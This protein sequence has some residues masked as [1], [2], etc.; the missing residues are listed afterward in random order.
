[1]TFERPFCWTF[2]E[3]NTQSITRFWCWVK[4][5]LWFQT[6]SALLQLFG[7]PQKKCIQGGQSK[8]LPLTRVGFGRVLAAFSTDFLPASAWPSTALWFLP[9]AGVTGPGTCQGQ[10][11]A[12]CFRWALKD[13]KG[14]YE[15]CHWPWIASGSPALLFLKSNSSFLSCHTRTHQNTPAFKLERKLEIKRAQH[16]SVFSWSRSK[17]KAT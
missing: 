13:V 17:A 1:M 2:Q 8:T 3:I 16:G 12:T 7:N 15:C 14:R 9:K 5:R 4:C 11:W 6:A 10:W